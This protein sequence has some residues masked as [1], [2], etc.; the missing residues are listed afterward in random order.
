MNDTATN[1]EVNSR[2][3][4]L[5][6]SGEEAHRAL[7]GF[8]H[9]MGF[10][11]GNVDGDFR[12]NSNSAY[13]Q[14][15]DQYS[16]L[17]ELGINPNAD[18]VNSALQSI[19]SALQ[20]DVAFQRQYVTGIN[21]AE[22]TTQL[23]GALVAGGSWANRH[24]GD[25]ISEAEPIDIDGDRGI[26]TERGTRNAA[27]LTGVATLQASLNLLTGSNLENRG[28]YDEETNA[29]IRSYAEENGIELTDNAQ[30]NFTVVQQYIQDN[31]GEALR[32]KVSEAL[33]SDQDYSAPDERT[34]DAQIVMNG[35]ARQNG[36]DV[37]TAPDAR[38]TDQLITVENSHTRNVITEEANVD[39]TSETPQIVV[40]A[41]P[42]NQMYEITRS[43]VL[44]DVQS[45]AD[46]QRNDPE[47]AQSV[48]AYSEEARGFVLINQNSHDDNSTIYQVSDQ[49]VDDIMSQ[50]ENGSI[51]IDSSASKVIA[52]QMHGNSSETTAYTTEEIRNAFVE[53]ASRFTNNTRESLLTASAENSEG[54]QMRFGL[55]DL[56][57]A[58]D[59]TDSQS[60]WEGSNNPAEIQDYI[61]GLRQ[62]AED[63]REERDVTIP[64]WNGEELNESNSV[65]VKIGDHTAQIP[66]EVWLGISAQME[67]SES[68]F[69]QGE[70]RSALVIDTMDDLAPT[71]QPNDLTAGFDKAL[72]AQ[73]PLDVVEVVLPSDEVAPVSDDPSLTTDVNVDE[74]L[75]A[76]KRGEITGTVSTGGTLSEDGNVMLL[77]SSTP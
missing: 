57:D 41:S 72:A 40:T 71:A 73:E 50:I 25:R 2:P 22:N 27:S 69:S 5:M 43:D 37:R 33:N 6:P 65:E 53:D 9:I 55:D 4:Q 58:L 63:A 1:N 17:P 14:A 51:A 52:E 10:N 67:A 59:K 75:E 32:A 26:L 56:H 31:E 38:Q 76:L 61:K 74:A 18:A 45:I 29:A 48:L 77:G 20:N 19:D 28:I 30:D 21:G 11:P 36:S 8:L 15:R 70:S 24:L 44:S 39:L 35:M 42:L 47:S 62:A 16:F 23:Q 49:N 68:G 60:D 3:E 34:R 66:T 7:Q 13:N 54:T 64:Q 46:S 12:E